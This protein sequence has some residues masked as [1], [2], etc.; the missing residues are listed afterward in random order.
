ML[1]MNH[2]REL[3]HI[4]FEVYLNEIK[5]KGLHLFDLHCVSA[6]GDEAASSQLKGGRS[7]RDFDMMV[8]LE[9]GLL[10]ASLNI[11]P[12]ELLTSALVM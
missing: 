12:R 3:A 5:G 10:Q 1:A 7:I 8:K 4:T 9:F 11:K 6:S 2:V